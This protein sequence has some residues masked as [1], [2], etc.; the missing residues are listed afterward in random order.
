VDQPTQPEGIIMEI[1]DY[2]RKAINEYKANTQTMDS[3]TA[4]SR[5]VYAI[6]STAADESKAS[7]GSAAKV[8]RHAIEAYETKAS[9]GIADAKAMESAIKDTAS[10]FDDRGRDNARSQERPRSRGMGL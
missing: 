3:D 4:K 5:A 10:R 2:S 6:A 8:A 9:A 7:I 1:A